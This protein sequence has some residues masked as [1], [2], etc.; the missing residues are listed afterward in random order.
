MVAAGGGQMQLEVEYDVIQGK[1]GYLFLHTGTNDNFAYV[2]FEK[3]YP[4]A[5]LEKLYG[6]WLE[7]RAYAAK[8][9]S[10]YEVMIFPNKET[11]C[12]DK[13]PMSAVLD[14]P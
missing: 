2:T 1:D 5:A 14:A 11:L 4:Q 13:H 9:G 6:Q 8:R 3:R 10:D 7:A 12:W